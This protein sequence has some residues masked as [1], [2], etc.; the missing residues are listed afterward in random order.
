MKKQSGLVVALALVLSACSGGSS[1]DG[2]RLGRPAVEVSGLAAGQTVTVRLNDM[3]SDTLVFSSNGRQGFSARVNNSERHTVSRI[4]QVGTHC[5]FAGN[6]A[7]S[8]SSVP[9]QVHALACGIPDEEEPGGPGEPGG[10]VTLQLGLMLTDAGGAQVGTV[11]NPITAARPGRLRAQFSNNG[12]PIPNRV[13]SFQ[14]TLGQLHPISGT[15][16]TDNTGIAQIELRAGQSAGA[17]VVTVRASYGGGNIEREYAFQT[18]GDSDGSEPVPVEELALGSGTGGSFQEGVLNVSS[19]SISAGSTV[20]VSGNIVAQPGNTAWPGVAEVQLTSNCSVQG[21]AEIDS[22]V[23]A[24]AGSFFASY[25][26]LAGCTVDVI[27]ATAVLS[28]ES[29]VALS[30]EVTVSQAPSNSISFEGATPPVIGLRGSAQANVPETSVLRF[31]VQDSN[32]DP[33]GAGTNVEFDVVAG[34]GG[35]AITSDR[36]GTTNSSGVVSVTVRSGTVP[37]VGTVRA[38]VIGSSIE[39][40][41]SV[42][43]QTGIASQ[44]SFSIA[45]RTLNPPAGDHL[46]VQVEV[47]VRAADRFGNWVQDGTQVNFTTELGDIQPSCETEGGGC[48]VTWVSQ[49]METKHFDANRAGRTSPAECYSGDPN[50]RHR[51]G[52]LNTVPCGLHDRFGRS[53]I[54]AWAVGEEAFT[55][56]NGNNIFDMGENW[57]ALPEAFRDD[58]E[59]GMFT[60][61]MGATNFFMDFDENGAYD[62]AG[63]HFRGLGCS[64]AASGAGHCEQLANVRASGVIVLSTDAVNIYVLPLA[65]DFTGMAWEAPTGGSPQSWKNTVLRG[66]TSTVA[67]YDTLADGQV[68]GINLSDARFRVVVAD[69]NG[70]APALGTTLQLDGGDMDV[71]GAT[72]CEMFNSTEPMI[73]DFRVRYTGS[74]TGAIAPIVFTAQSGNLTYFRDIDVTVP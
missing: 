18:T 30:P 4:A 12:T 11:D 62:V 53:T 42:S 70:N 7:S 32:G 64:A 6:S 54:T 24:I 57:V 27:R 39:G 8:S 23:N 41:G 47:T 66:V 21:R 29:Q 25:R 61:S 44:D 73:C 2:V 34:T 16:L 52:L 48:S 31:E 40:T 55:D 72:S 15:A 38:R 10:E 1:S 68:T 33:V 71:V 17:G 19:S 36:E 46:G 3:A 49:G 51:E 69:L 74:E 37:T 28:G 50:I 63:S 14:T 26:P 22:P 56:T 5:V 45:V 67:G 60:D 35:F 58:N 20:N 65:A 43:V 59:T 13:V 9:N